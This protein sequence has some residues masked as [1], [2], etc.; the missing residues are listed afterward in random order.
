MRDG[1]RVTVEVRADGDG[2]VSHA[3]SA[4]VA[5]IA[6]KAG[7]TAGLS[8]GLAGLKQRRS[9]HDPGR[10]VR[11]LAVMLADGGDCLA[12][13]GAVGDQDALF[14][15]VA[16]DFTALRIIVVVRAD[17]AGATHDLLDFCREHRLCY[18]VGYELSEQVRAAILKVPEA[19]WIASLTTDGS[20]ART[21]RS[22][23]SPT[24]W[25]SPHG[26]RGRG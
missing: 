16:S 11:D 2:V 23:R 21:G 20:R 1:R 18:S 9:G 6:D 12:D 3:G 25:T 4:L 10:V 15:S 26:R 22:S 17:S 19:S 5:L 13:F 8:A 14:G 24:C 7:L